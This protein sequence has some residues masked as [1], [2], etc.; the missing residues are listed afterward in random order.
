MFGWIGQV[1]ELETL[2]II[3][4][5]ART[6]GGKKVDSVGVMKDKEIQPEEI[7]AFTH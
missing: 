1:E 6:K 3:T 2:F 7:E 5:K 4:D